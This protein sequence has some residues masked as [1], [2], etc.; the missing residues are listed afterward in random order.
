MMFPNMNSV[1]KKGFILKIKELNAA[2][3][4]SNLSFDA[5]PFFFFTFFF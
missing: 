1:L 3:T 2:A 5:R 4:T